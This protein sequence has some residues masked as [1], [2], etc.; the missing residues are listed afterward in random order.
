[1]ND[2]YFLII[3]FYGFLIL[4]IITIFICF[5]KKYNF[6]KLLCLFL[7]IVLSIIGIVFF[8]KTLKTINYIE[9]KDVKVISSH[10][11]DNYNVDYTNDYRSS[12]TDIIYDYEYKDNEGYTYSA[13]GGEIEPIIRYNMNDHSDYVVGSFFDLAKIY[14]IITIIGVVIIVSTIVLSRIN[15]NDKK[16]KS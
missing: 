15:N 16:K 2:V 10:T 14:I 3:G 6:I 7:G 1:M 12:D 9:S 5:K 13:T 8:L 11:I 4:L